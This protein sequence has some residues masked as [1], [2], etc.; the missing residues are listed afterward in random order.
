M[1][2]G[3]FILWLLP[4]VFLI[5]NNYAQIFDQEKDDEF[6][7]KSL[8]GMYKTSCKRCHDDDTCDNED[9]GGT[10]Q[11]EQDRL[12]CGGGTTSTCNADTIVAIEATENGNDDNRD[13]D[14]DQEEHVRS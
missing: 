13:D 2:N 4:I 3:N 9:V 14:D 8:A 1:K 5:C 7:C 11:M 6:Y 12:N 10:D